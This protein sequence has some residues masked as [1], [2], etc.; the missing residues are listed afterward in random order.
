MI[1]HLRLELI[2]LLIHGFQIVGNGF[3][4]FFRVPKGIIALDIDGTLTS[5]THQVHPEVIKFLTSLAEEKWEFIFITGRP[6]QWGFQS[7]YDLPFSYAL[8]VQ[9][10]A[11]T[12]E[13][14]TREILNKQ[15]LTP[16]IFPAI[17]SICEKEQTDFVVYL[18]WEYNDWCYYRPDHFDP[19]LLEYLNR[20]CTFL[21]EKWQ[22]V[23]DFTSL[24]A[25]TVASLK[26]FAKEENQAIRLG[27]QVEAKTE[28][29]APINRD[30]FDPNYFVIQMTHP[31]ATKGHALK[32]FMQSFPTSVPVIAAGDDYN[33]LSM[34][35]IANVKVVMNT[36]PDDLKVIADVVAPAASENGIIEGLKKAI[37]KVSK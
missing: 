31:E 6:F 37:E 20:R 18:G 26:C 2:G 24:P 32:H 19:S 4:M 25:S 8:A 34:L 17:E 21:K 13:M 28:L 30:P 36:A 29:H 23:P 3:F 16:S 22:P 12:L 9:N 1:N 10:G 5:E 27:R 11:L 33:D 14:P 35:K 7:L 15:Y